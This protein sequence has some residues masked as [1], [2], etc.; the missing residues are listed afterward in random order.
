MTA[1]PQFITV[2]QLATHAKRHPESVRRALRAAGLMPAA[3]KG[4]KGKRISVTKANRFLS[5]Q[6]PGTPLIEEAQP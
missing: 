4:I 3:E 6:W 2:A 5:R 1:A